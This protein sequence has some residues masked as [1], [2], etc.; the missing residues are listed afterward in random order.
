M[1]ATELEIDGSQADEGG[2]IWASDA[3]LDCSDCTLSDNEA[4]GVGGHLAAYGDAQV[5]F[6]GGQLTEG[7]SLGDGGAGWIEGATLALYDASVT[8]NTAEQDGGA[9]ALPDSSAQLSLDNVTLH[10]NQAIAGDGGA[11]SVQ[12][13]TL[14]IQESWLDGNSAGQGGGAIALDGAELLLELSELSD[15]QADEA[16][17]A[18]S[19]TDSTVQTSGLTIDGNQ[20][21]EGGGFQMVDS[22]LESS[23]DVWSANISDGRGGG[24]LL[25]SQ[26][27][28]SAA[29]LADAVFEANQ[30]EDGGGIALTG[31][32][33]H[34]TA[35]FVDND[36]DDTYN[37]GGADSDTWTGEVE[38]SCDVQTCD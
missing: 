26:I 25:D 15:N 10:H 18:L 2:A 31:S 19:A 11:M 3:Q 35:E 16:G 7:A 38:I 21:D 17:G 13:G 1:L 6:Y 34:A 27:T 22:T 8:H 24:L 5:V 30:A 9:F 36:P 14:S 29:E 4:T 12:L 33:L 32:E 28:G 23:D 20:A 37:T